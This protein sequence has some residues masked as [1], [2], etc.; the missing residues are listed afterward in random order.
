MAYCHEKA[1]PHSVFLEQWSPEDRDKLFAYAFEKA[2]QCVCGTSEWEWEENPYAY[3]ATVQT[4]Q[5]CQ[6][7][8]N[9]RDGELPAGA[10]IVLVPAAQAAMMHE[11]PKRGVRRRRTQDG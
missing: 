6:L 10:S 8:E 9:S 11:Q 4:C 2:T 1:I 7:K 3:T 5:G